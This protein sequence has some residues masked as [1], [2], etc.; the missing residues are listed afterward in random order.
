MSGSEPNDHPGGMRPDREMAALE[1]QIDVS[2]QRADD[3]ASGRAVLRRRSPVLVA[4]TVFLFVALL[5]TA[6]LA[7]YLWRT[8]DE[9]RAEADR[10]TTVATD[11][12][13]ERDDLAAD[14]DQAQRDLEATEEQLRQVQDRLLSLAEER[15]QTGDELEAIRLLANNVA[16]VAGELEACVRSQEQLIGVLEEVELYDPDSV[17]QGT[18]QISAACA[19]A[20]AGSEELKREL[21]VE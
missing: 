12:A 10:V 13:A 14:L 19:D 21:G 9:W 1:R 7:A 18:E 17:A 15:A 20:L 8:T 6:A 5:A 4:L 11:V 16:R 3:A 2:L